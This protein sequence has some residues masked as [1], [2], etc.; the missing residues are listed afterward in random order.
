MS[1]KYNLPWYRILKADGSIALARG[2]GFEV[3]AGLLQKEG[4]EV[5]K[6]GRVD[7]EKYLWRPKLPN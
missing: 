5:S 6:D 2:A 4:V 7:L 1:E 3:Q